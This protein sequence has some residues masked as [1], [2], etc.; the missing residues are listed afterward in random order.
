[1][2]VLSN[3]S[4]VFVVDD[5]IIQGVVVAADGVLTLQLCKVGVELM[6]AKVAL[7]KF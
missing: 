7:F 6:C 2:V 4:Q 1:M 3:V 5:V